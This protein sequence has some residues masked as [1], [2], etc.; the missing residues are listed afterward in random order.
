[1]TPESQQLIHQINIIRE[2]ASEAEAI[3]K[4]ITSDIQRLDVAKRNLTG[5]ITAVKRWNMMRECLGSIEGEQWG[6]YR[7]L[8]ELSRL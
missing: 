5:A 8:D 3:V 7:C 4:H 2:K 1:L 6:S